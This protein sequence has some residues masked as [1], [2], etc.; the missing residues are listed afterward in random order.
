MPWQIPNIG[1]MAKK[2]KP[3][4]N[5]QAT[6]YL[7]IVSILYVFLFKFYY[8]IALPEVPYK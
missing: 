3:N 7:I 8:F 5:N 6:D 2:N 4:N 1:E